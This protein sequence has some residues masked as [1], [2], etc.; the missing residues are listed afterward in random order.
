ML[1]R[2][3]AGWSGW[4]IYTTYHNVYRNGRPIGWE[5]KGQLFQI[6]VRPRG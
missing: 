6:V 4:V 3:G 5:T 1:T 2:A